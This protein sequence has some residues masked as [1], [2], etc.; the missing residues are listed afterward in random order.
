MLKKGIF[1]ISIDTELAWGTFEH[2]GHL[3]YKDAY[4]KYRLLISELLKLFEKYEI[5]ATWSIVGHLFLDRCSKENGK[6]HPDIVRPN[7]SWYKNDWFDCD[8]G[9]DMSKDN[10]WYGS[11][12]VKMIQDAAPE[13]EIASHSFGHPIFSDPGCFRATAESDIA[14]CVALARDKGIK[15]SSFTFPRNSPGHLDV[16]VEHGFKIFRGK[17][18]TSFNFRPPILRKAMLL[19]GD[20]FAATPPVVE[21]HFIAGSELIELKGSMLFRFAHGASRFIPKDVR[22]KKA[23]KGIDS[24]IREGKIFNLWFHPISFAWRTSEMLDEFEKILKYASKKQKA[25]DLKILTLK[26]IG[27][28]YAKE[29][30]DNDSYNPEAITLHN[31]RSCLF[32][33][34]YSDDLSSYHSNAFKYGRK[35]VERALLSFLDNLNP[36]GRIV[37]VGSGTGYYLNVMNKRG[38]DCIGVDLAEKMIRQSRSLYPTIPVQRADARN[39]PF[40]DDSLDAVVSIETLRYFSDQHAFLKEIQRALKPGGMLF[41]TAAPLLSMNTYGIFNSLCRF[42]NLKSFVSCFQS[43]ETAESLK[44]RL[45]EAGFELVSVKGYFFGPYFLLD[46]IQPKLSSFLMRHLEGTDDKLGKLNLIRNFSNHLVAIA[47]KPYK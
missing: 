23:E 21:P 11:D 15:L 18:A 27:D 41:V 43:F 8:P 19:L 6:L 16:L 34:G 17:D 22:F 12:I 35:K 5:S 39:L 3:K 28:M 44:R 4:K 10:F 36:G 25:G 14:K 24:A 33:E 1:T 45:E 29:K 32:K 2:G 46:K 7:Y 37:E 40:S 31:D 47:R 26:E 13:Q 42:F 30:K 38:F 20:M 9:T